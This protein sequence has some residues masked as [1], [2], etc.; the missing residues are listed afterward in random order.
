[1]LEKTFQAL[2]WEQMK[3]YLTLCYQQ[4]LTAQDLGSSLNEMLPNACPLDQT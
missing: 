4:T 2:G 1:M 3:I